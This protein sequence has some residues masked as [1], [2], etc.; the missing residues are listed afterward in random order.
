MILDPRPRPK[1][2]AIEGLLVEMLDG[3]A[4]EMPRAPSLEDAE[5]EELLTL[6]PE[7]EA[8]AEQPLALS[9]EEE[10]AAAE[11]LSRPIAGEAACQGKPRR[12]P[13]RAIARGSRG[14]RVP[15]A[16]GVVPLLLGHQEDPAQD[17]PHE[18]PDICHAGP[19]IS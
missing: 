3:A 17:G 11:E 6:S 5:A 10:A 19:T 1:E 4:V 18:R 7:E 12:G 8:A 16:I 15:R 14:S 2:A 13:S 9:P